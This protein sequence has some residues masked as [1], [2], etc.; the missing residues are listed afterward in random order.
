MGLTGGGSDHEPGVTVFDRRP[1]HFYSAIYNREITALKRTFNLVSQPT[2]PKVARMPYIPLLAEN[3]V[4]KGF[5][6]HGDF[7]ALS[8]ALPVMLEL[9]GRP[10]RG[11]NG[12]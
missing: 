2:P 4:R 11:L 12:G 9:T 7:L 10:E 3:N 1:I 5:F 6:E 8:E